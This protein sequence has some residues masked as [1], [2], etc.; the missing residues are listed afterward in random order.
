MKWSFREMNNT[1]ESIQAEIAHE[2]K[3]SDL[4]SSLIIAN[5]EAVAQNIVSAFPKDQQYL[6]DAKV[7]SLEVWVSRLCSLL[8]SSEVEYLTGILQN[9]VAK[10]KERV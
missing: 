7:G 1:T 6:A 8:P 3:K 5:V 9:V 4:L 2:F 10:V